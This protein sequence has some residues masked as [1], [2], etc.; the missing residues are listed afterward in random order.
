MRLTDYLRDDLVLTGLAAPDTGEILEVLCARFEARGIVH[1]GKEAARALLAREN[2]H[3][4]VLEEGVAVPHATLQDLSRMVLLVATAPVPLPFGPP[5][6]SP[7]DVFFVLL[8]PPG[9]EG[10]HIKLLA[11]I[12][13]LVR[14]PGFLG[15][16][17][18]AEGE[19]DLLDVIRRI[20]SEHV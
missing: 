7:V 18:S 19:A 2:D 14:H 10:V 13:R 16:L 1:S 20:D 6:T 5:E 3:T 8:S 12:C 9:S 11:R 15:D 17:R 4:T